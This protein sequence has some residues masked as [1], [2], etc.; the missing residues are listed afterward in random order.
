MYEVQD[1]PYCYPGTAVLRNLLGIEA[2]DTLEALE[3]EL[4]MTRADEPLPSGKLDADH[5][6][7]IHHHLFQ[8]VYGWAGKPRTVRISKRNSHFCFPEWIDGELAKLFRGLK[9]E[10]FLKGLS[11]EAFAR[12]AA[13]FLATLNVIHAFREGNGRAQLSFLL[14]LADNAGHPLD[15]SQMDPETMLHA[16]IASFEGDEEPLVQLL[17][18]MIP[19]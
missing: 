15:I 12:K 13:T 8:D 11:P 9:Q 4:A 5:Y 19:N 3:T 14:L 7:A 16:M 6:L 1:D 10:R 18:L 2:E 17:L